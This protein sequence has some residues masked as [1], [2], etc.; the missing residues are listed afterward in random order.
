[1]EDV[2]A[3]SLVNLK[4]VNRN[5]GGQSSNQGI[6]KEFFGQLDK[7]ILAALYERY[8]PDFVLHGYTLDPFLELLL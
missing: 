2:S 7:D 1:M 5:P 3:A 6:S 8:E 4:H